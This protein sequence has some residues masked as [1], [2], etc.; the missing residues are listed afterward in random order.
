MVSLGR[1]PL[2]DK[3]NFNAL[4]SPDGMKRVFRSRKRE[5]A[6][7]Y[8]NRILLKWKSRRVVPVIEEVPVFSSRF[9]PVFYYVCIPKGME[10]SL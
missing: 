9:G 4:R 5:V 1:L 8:L 2:S 10:V 7:D 6:Q 3:I